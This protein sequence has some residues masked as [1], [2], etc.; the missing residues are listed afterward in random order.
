LDSQTSSGASISQDPDYDAVL[1]GDID[2]VNAARMK[3]TL[4]EA[5]ER[6]QRG[7]VVVHAAAVTFIDSTG[8]GALI[9]VASHA[10]QCSRRLVFTEPSERLRL[11][12]KTTGLADVFPIVEADS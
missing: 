2:S 1:F 4:I 8:L 6:C 9:A 5:I 3:V 10:R 11:L 7:L 12:I